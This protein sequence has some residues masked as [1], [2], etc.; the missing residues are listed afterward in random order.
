MANR[1]QW[2]STTRENRWQKK[3]AA[4][5]GSSAVGL[6]LTGSRHQTI[7]GFGGCFNELAW[8]AMNKLSREDRE[9]IVKELFDQ[10]DGCK[11]TLCRMPIGANDFSEIWYSLNEHDGDY[12]MERFSMERD[13]QV[14]IP[15]IR[16]AM[17]HQPDLKLFA[18]PWSPPSW[19]KFPKVYNY[20]KLVWEPR[21]LNAYALYFKKFV[22]A[23]AAEGIRIDQVHIQNEPCADQK[24]PSCLWTGQE[25]RDFI[26]DYIG[27]LFEQ[28]GLD[29]EIWLGTL[30]C[31]D[32]DAFANVVLS[33]E[34]A[35]RYVAGVGYQWIGR[36]AIQKTHESWPE[37]RLMQTECECG[38]GQNTWEYAKYV[39]QLFQHYLS[40]GAGSFIYWNM[41]LETGGSST[42][43]WKQNSLV[44]VDAEKR[45]YVYNPEFYVM[46]HVSH[47]VK[48]GAVRLGLA[49]SWTGNALAFENPD[50]ELVLT[51]ANPLDAART[52]TV[53]VDGVSYAFE[54]EPESFHTV[55]I[56]RGQAE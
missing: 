17:K 24:F 26:R 47:Y 38:N 39:F 42:W 40:N 3:E 33:D 4:A 25:M 2:V 52:L 22:E 37:V 21:N 29:T 49:G 28:A 45:T 51:F 32:Y 36:E 46:K 50:G 27:P 48:P 54:C 13:R 41:A 30:N 31:K 56:G 1:V 53:E 19:M 11:F 34:A 23:Y 12:E 15:Y 55:A 44:T 7:E 9:A 10:E 5:G 8:I 20:G 16:E 18:S 14:L 43:G 6:K 35:R